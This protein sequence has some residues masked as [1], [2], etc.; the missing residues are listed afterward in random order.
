VLHGAVKKEV[1]TPQLPIES[2]S[3]IARVRA[4]LGHRG[5][6][7]LDDPCWRL[8][9]LAPE[10]VERRFVEA[11][12]HGFLRYQAAG[13]VVRVE[14]PEGSLEEYASVLTR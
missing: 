11:Q 12:Q 6:R 1:V 14:F 5:A 4:E 13:S 2:F 10:S 8:F 9:F 3:F 7:A